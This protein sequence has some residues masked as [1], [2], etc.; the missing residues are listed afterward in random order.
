MFYILRFA[1]YWVFWHL[2]YTLT[3]EINGVLRLMGQA[4]IAFSSLYL[5]IRRVLPP[6]KFAPSQ[7]IIT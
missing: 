5:G 3:I 6:T 4:V 7:A 2:A 1:F